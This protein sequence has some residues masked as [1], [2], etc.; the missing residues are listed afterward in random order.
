[1]ASDRQIEAN[2]ANALKSTGP[3][4]PETRAK[5]AQNSTRHGLLAQNNLLEGE[6][7]ERFDLLLA[8]MLEDLQPENG[9]ESALIETLAVSRWR[10]MRVWALENATINKEIRNQVADSE[11]DDSTTRAATAIRTLCDQSNYLEI[12]SRYETRYDR[13]YLRTLDRLVRLRQKKNSDFA[14]RTQFD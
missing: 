11:E 4:S 1:M 5:S 3:L 7:K 14:K 12:M 10:Q 6:S 13:Q 8:T 9:V 2:R